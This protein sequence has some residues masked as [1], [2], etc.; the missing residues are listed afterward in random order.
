M[1]IIPSGSPGSPDPPLICVD[2]ILPFKD[3]QSVMLRGLLSSSHCLM[4]GGLA[5]FNWL[6]V[7]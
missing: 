3:A 5:E 4:W 7:L 2:Q 1:K 6:N